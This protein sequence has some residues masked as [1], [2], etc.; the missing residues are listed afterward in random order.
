M[1]SEVKR[2]T[3]QRGGHAMTVVHIQEASGAAPA[4]LRAS[5]HWADLQMD[6]HTQLIGH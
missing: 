3:V 6:A 2:A 5:A 1:L 4:R